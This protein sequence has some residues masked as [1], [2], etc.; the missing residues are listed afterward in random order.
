MLRQFRHLGEGDA[1]RQSFTKNFVELDKFLRVV[2]SDR[3]TFERTEYAHRGGAQ[4]GRIFRL[5][6]RLFKGGEPVPTDF[7]D[8]AASLGRLQD[9]ADHGDGVRALQGES[10]P[11]RAG[12]IG[13][14]A[15]DERPCCGLIAPRERSGD[16]RGLIRVTEFG[17]I[18]PFTRRA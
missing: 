11:C 16:G 17:T 5:T 15:F 1:V 13:D 6:R 2:A 3:L 7:R 9:R 14:R 10:S 12:G 4:F 8:E 18:R